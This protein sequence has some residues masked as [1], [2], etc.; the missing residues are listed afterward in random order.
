[1]AAAEASGTARRIGL[2]ATVLSLVGLGASA[3]LTRAHYTTATVL[4]CPDRGVVNCAKVT[5]SSYATFL[6][7][8]VAVL[9]LAFFAAVLPLELPAAWRSISSILRIGRMA[10]LSGGVAMVLWLIYAEL[11]RLDAICLW[12]TVVHV[13]TVALFVLTGLGTAATAPGTTAWDLD[14]VELAAETEAEELP[15]SG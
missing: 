6:H 7:M 12:C 14:E 4:A 13:V 5:T 8:P 11:F 3:Y 2:A 10:L 1:V 9:G 15:A